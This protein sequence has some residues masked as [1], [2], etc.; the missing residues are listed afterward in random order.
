MSE[1]INPNE[2]KTQPNTK[3]SHVLGI[4]AS[5][6]A[7]HNKALENPTQAATVEEAWD[8]AEAQ[9]AVSLLPVYIENDQF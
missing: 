3:S 5:F 2:R 1:T 6:R 9:R 4:E 8:Y 7:L